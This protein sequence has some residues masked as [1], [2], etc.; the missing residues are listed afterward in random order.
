MND[1]KKVWQNVFQDICKTMTYT[2]KYSFLHCNPV[3]GQYWARTGF[4]LCS[5]STQGKNCF[6]C[7]VPSWWKQVFPRWKY[8]TG[9]TLFSLQ[10]L[11]CSVVIGASHE[12]SYETSFASVLSEFALRERWDKQNKSKRSTYEAPLTRKTRLNSDFII[13]TINICDMA[14][15]QQTEI[16]RQH[17]T[18]LTYVC[19]Y[20]IL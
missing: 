13:R 2:L 1:K 14:S 7:R 3:Q 4:S 11:V 20:C 18:I 15:W 9:K 10:G 17:V 16:L 5:I 8:Y 6:Y 12:A 19:T